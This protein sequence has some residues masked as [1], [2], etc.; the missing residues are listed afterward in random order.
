MMR[1]DRGCWRGVPA[2]AHKVRPAAGAPLQAWR[3]KDGCRPAFQR[4]QP[5]LFEQNRGHGSAG[6]GHPSHYLCG[7]MVPAAIRLPL[8]FLPFSRKRLEAWCALESTS[9]AAGSGAA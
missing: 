5:Y 3:L 8:G 6:D 7:M 4:A 1:A 9:A 2:I